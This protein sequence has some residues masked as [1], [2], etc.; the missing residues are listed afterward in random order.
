MWLLKLHLEENGYRTYTIELKKLGSPNDGSGWENR[1]IKQ[2]TSLK[3]TIPYLLFTRIKARSL[4][5][6]PAPKDKPVYQEELWIQCK[7]QGTFVAGRS[8]EFFCSNDDTLL[9][10]LQHLTLISKLV[11]CQ[12]I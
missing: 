3:W 6:L 5:N 8:I 9:H 7:D 2:P 1:F 10:I 12:T 11:K 4:D